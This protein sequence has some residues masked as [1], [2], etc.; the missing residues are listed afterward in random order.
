MNMEALIAQTVAKMLAGYGEKNDPVPAHDQGSPYVHGPGGPGAL[1]GV[2]SQPS[3]SPDMWATVVNP[4]TP[5][6]LLFGGTSVVTNPQYPIWT[7]ITDDTGTPPADACDEPPVAGSPK[8]CIQSS[9]FGDMTKKTPTRD[10]TNVGAR[11]NNGEVERRVINNL[12]LNNPLVPQLSSGAD[13]NDQATM[14]LL[15]LGYSM[16][17]DLSRLIFQGNITTAAGASSFGAIR[18]FDGFDVLISTG[19]VDAITQVACP[20][21]D[22]IVEDF[23]HVTVATDAS[24]SIVEWVTGVYYALT[25]GRAERMGIMD[26]VIA[27]MMDHDLFYRLTQVWPCSYLTTGCNFTG[28]DGNSLNVGG[29]EQTQ[30]RDQMRRGSFLWIDGQQ[31]PVITTDGPAKTAVGPGFSSS[32]YFVPLRANGQRVTWLEAFDQSN[33]EAMRFMNI[34]GSPNARTLNG[35]VYSVVRSEK[36]WCVNYALRIKP[37]LIMRTPFLAA[38]IDNVNFALRH[39]VRSPY[40]GDIYYA[41]GGQTYRTAPT[42]Y[43]TGATTFPQQ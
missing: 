22:S 21:A 43:R 19:K 29:A 41:N 32:I 6:Q 27:I 38:R 26:L 33:S 31:V 17:L 36:N 1:S 16:L 39:Y 7:G 14:D 28:S 42:L 35:G 23:N 3:V 34:A 37:R 25:K 30:M 2:F 24:E 12:M 5:A 20:A 4:V 8:E 40:H 18:E 10:W 13:I 15:T 9:G 11:L